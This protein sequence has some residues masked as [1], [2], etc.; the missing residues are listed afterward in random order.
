MLNRRAFL[1][2]TIAAA[3]A[4]PL[5]A[6]AQRPAKVALIGVLCSITF[7][8]AFSEGLRELGYVYHRNFVIE[9]HDVAEG[10]LPRVA[11]ELARQSVSVIVACTTLKADAVRSAT[12][13]IP[14]IAV[15]EDPVGSG[16]AASL[17]RPGGN[18]TG[19][20]LLSPEAGAKR[21]ELL[22]E[23]VPQVS[24]I[25]VFWSLFR[26]DPVSM[27]LKGMQDAARALGTEFIILG[28]RRLDEYDDVLAAVKAHAEAVIV[29][30][31][32]VVSPYESRLMELLALHRLPAMFDYGD[33]AKAG[34]LMSFGFSIP[35][36]A[37]RAATYVDKILKGAKP[38][39]LPIEQPTK[40]EL[41][42][43]VKTARALGLTIPPSLLLR[44]DQVI[45]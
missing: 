14:I 39:D 21:L 9:S 5:A 13:T 4:V 38:A 15:A 36:V 8:E 41:V 27:E 42:I 18:V 33:Y 35:A 26:P 44:A 17:P 40:F 10:D 11:A 30:T 32:S 45:E 7:R 6:E 29:L 22:K 3:L 25:A 1:C 34:G 20:A 31:D 24:R 12:T 19:L 2:Q 37:R 43:N 23:A 16:L 28:R